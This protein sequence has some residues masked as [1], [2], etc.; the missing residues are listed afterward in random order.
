MVTMMMMMITDYIII[1][2]TTIVTAIIGVDAS[3]SA[4][5]RKCHDYP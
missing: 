1:D 3:R 2:I 4:T 5:P